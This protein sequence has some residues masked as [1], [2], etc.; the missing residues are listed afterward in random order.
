MFIPASRLC[1]APSPL[2]ALALLSSVS[3][4]R[5]TFL[6]RAKWLA[7]CSRGCFTILLFCAH[8]PALHAM[9]VLR[10]SLLLSQEKTLSHLGGPSLRLP[11]LISTTS[12]R[13]RYLLLILRNLLFAMR[14][15]LSAPSKRP[16]LPQSKNARRNSLRLCNASRT[17]AIIAFSFL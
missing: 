15:S 10:R 9:N 2:A 3:I 5:P 12:L 1:S 14:N 13:R 7:Y 4:T 17:V 8:P 6:S 16:V 11:P